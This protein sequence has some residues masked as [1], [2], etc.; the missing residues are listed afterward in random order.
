METTDNVISRKMNELAKRLITNIM[1]SDR[2]WSLMCEVTIPIMQKMAVTGKSTD[3]CLQHGFLPVPIQ[4]YQP[5]PDIEELEK[6][7]VWDKVSSLKGIYFEPGEYLDFIRQLSIEYANE[8]TW[9]NDPSENP[10]QFHLHNGCFSYGCAAPLHCI[11]RHNKPKRIIEI[12]SGNSS[13]V[14]NSAIILNSQQG[15]DTIYTIIDPYSNLDDK[16]FYPNTIVIRKPVEL[17]DPE[18]FESLGENDILF[19]DSSHVCKMGSDVNFEIL[20]VLP[21]LKKGVYIHF[22]D[23]DLPYEYAKIYS[24]NPAFRVFWTESYLLQAFLACNKDFKIVLPMRYLQSTHGD[25][26]KEFFPE[27]AKTDFGFVSGS[28]WITRIS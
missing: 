7:G 25:D 26:L 27:S 1:R 10:M 6:R 24:T 21:S 12:G 14:I 15:H 11:I 16:N 9:P 28:F 3:K 18:F 20:E 17:M 5:I 13:K 19:I 2:M 8:C 22:H 23:V 4:F